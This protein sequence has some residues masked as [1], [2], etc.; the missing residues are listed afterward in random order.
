[1]YSEVTE[2]STLYCHCRGCSRQLQS[3]TAVMEADSV[4][5]RV[6]SPHVTIPQDQMKLPVTTTVLEI[7]TIL[8]T[9]LPSQ[10]PVSVSL[11][12]V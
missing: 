6:L 8:L 2:Y 3:R 7:K 11:C 1:M 9:S 10:P 12:T 5:I 4:K